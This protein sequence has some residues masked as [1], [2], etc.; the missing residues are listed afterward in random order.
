MSGAG[1]EKGQNQKVSAGTIIIEES[2]P[3][4]TLILLHSGTASYQIT[5]GQVVQVCDLS[6]P[7][8]LAFDSHLTDISSDVRIT[9]NN[10]CVI[11]VYPSNQEYIKKV[12][13]GKPNIALLAS[14]TLLLQLK[15]IEKKVENTLPVFRDLRR[16]YTGVVMS[17]AATIESPQQENTEL[18]EDIEDFTERY[19]RNDRSLP[20]VLSPEF[21]KGED[22]GDFFSNAEMPDH[23]PAF[24]DE[25]FLRI[26][27]LANEVQAKIA[28]TD[29][30][31]LTRSLAEIS[32]MI[33]QQLHFIDHLFDEM[34]KMKSILFD[35]AYSVVKQ[36]ATFADSMVSGRVAAPGDR[37]KVFANELLDSVHLFTD[38]YQRVNLDL[39]HV[40]EGLLSH[41]RAGIE[42]ESKPN[43]ALDEVMSEEL[44]GVYSE[45]QVTELFK[46][47]FRKICEF[48]DVPDELF[49]EFKKTWGDFRDSGKFNSGDSELRKE[50]RT[51]TK[52]FWEIYYHVIL[53]AVKQPESPPDFVMAFIDHGV[54]DEVVMRPEHL[55]LILKSVNDHHHSKYGIHHPLDWFKQIYQGELDTSINELGMTRFELLVQE[56]GRGKWK[57][58]ADLPPDM[59]KPEDLLK[60]ELDSMVAPN[61]RLTSGAISTFIPVLYSDAIYK[62]LEQSLVTPLTLEKEIDKLLKCDYSAYHREVLYKNKDF[63]ITSEFVQERV[64]PNFVLLPSAGDNFQFWQEREGRD[65]N[66]PG[67]ILCPAIALEDMYK[68]LLKA[69]SIYRWEML[70]TT[71]GVDWNNVSIPSITADY[72]DYMQFFR[73]NR[74]L[75]TEAKEKV[76]ADYKRARDDRGRFSNDY[77]IY[78]LQESQ[79]VQKF[80]KVAR[81]IFTKHIPFAR[82][83]REH[84]STLPNFADHIQKSYNIRRKR[85][86]ELLPKYKKIRN[87]NDGM[88][89]KELEENYDFWN[90]EW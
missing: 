43:S 14:R 76:A 34:V 41:I 8:V 88:L 53:K 27:S 55:S 50:R 23:A 42:T 78:M 67:R 44:P 52:L 29:P 73:K 70:K 65:K 64:I 15:G 80:N 6:G 21:C 66:S 45:E 62:P 13:A 20:K 46:G 9:A 25:L 10:D 60:Y 5:A 84:L 19:Q 59:K 61:A 22:L 4:P 57:K 38:L 82:E 1:L 48:G 12:F 31:I 89:P 90:M 35:S 47:A 79:G 24:G 83:F 54:I 39:P 68:L 58:P 3:V 69:T 75:S 74:E 40:D 63:G 81:K 85:A 30:A 56:H 86:A 51:I 28:A 49:S 26:A 32:D 2:S 36:A 17:F 11:S 37:F 87:G 77:M 71:L 16:L 33:Q 7:A 18:I 72:T